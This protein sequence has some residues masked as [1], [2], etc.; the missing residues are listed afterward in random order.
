MI[1]NISYKSLR[2]MRLLNNGVIHKFDNI[3]ICVKSLY[4]IQCQYQMYGLISF[5]NRVNNIQIYNIVNNENLVKVWGM[6]TTLHIMHK[7]DWLA[8]NVVYLDNNTWVD[9]M[10]E[11][12]SLDS[13]LVLDEILNFIKVHKSATK[14]EIE[15][16]LKYEC[17]KELMQWGGV[18]ILCTLQG[19]LYGV[20]SEKDEKRYVYNVQN[21][22]EIANYSDVI[23]DMLKRY[24]T[25]YGPASK[26]DFSH[27]AGLPLKAFE[28]EFYRL[29]NSLNNFILDGIT[30]YYTNSAKILKKDQLSNIEY[31]IVLGKFDPLL[32]CYENKRWILDNLDANIVW[33]TAGQIEGVILGTQGI[34]A[35]WRYKMVRYKIFYY[36]KQVKDITLS[37]KKQLNIKFKQLTDFMRHDKYDIKYY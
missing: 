13:S 14:K 23:S 7:W 35:T 17:R 21:N 24:F 37:E 29:E 19:F 20:L 8:L 10:C 32:V 30:Y 27:W 5:F 11:R 9:K 6:R 15:N 25:F 2:E 28:T 1:N 3:D 33:G 12:L 34:L 26:M 16:S 22:S 18:L 4:G 31:P 36:I